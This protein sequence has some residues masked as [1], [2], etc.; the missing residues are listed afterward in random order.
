MHQNC[1]TA[2]NTKTE[3]HEL[4]N[5]TYFGGHSHCA[6]PSPKYA[7][8]LLVG[9]LGL[10]PKVDG[11]TVYTTGSPARPVP[12]RPGQELHSEELFGKAA[13]VR[14]APQINVMVLC[15]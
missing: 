13:A 9:S 10:A 3:G 4:H 5:G 12:E 15:C 2:N 14:C 7:D 6:A 8:D 1:A 11:V